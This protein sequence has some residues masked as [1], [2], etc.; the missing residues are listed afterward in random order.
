MIE[1]FIYYCFILL[2]IFVIEFLFNATLFIVFDFYYLCYDFFIL[3]INEFRLSKCQ[4][5]STTESLS[6]FGSDQLLD[7][8]FAAG[9]PPQEASTALA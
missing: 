1:T 8:N 2:L 6:P 9:L 4:L 5:F 7:T 3:S